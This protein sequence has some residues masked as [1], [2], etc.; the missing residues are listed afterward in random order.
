MGADLSTCQRA[1]LVDAPGD[2]IE[3]PFGIEP[4]DLPLDAIC[5]S[6]EIS[7]R[8]ALGERDVPAQLLPIDYCLL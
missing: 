2:E 3:E 5:R 6:I 8:E 1:G 4:N 7:V